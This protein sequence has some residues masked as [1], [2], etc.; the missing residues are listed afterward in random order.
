MMTDNKTKPSDVPPPRLADELYAL[1][2]K[3]DL[4][5]PKRESEYMGFIKDNMR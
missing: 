1:K 3:Q 2:K 4:L 5:K